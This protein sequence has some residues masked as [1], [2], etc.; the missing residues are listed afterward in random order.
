MHGEN[1]TSNQGPVE[2]G[3]HTMRSGLSAHPALLIPEWRLILH[4][5]P[6][7]HISVSTTT[8][9]LTVSSFFVPHFTQQVF[10]SYSVR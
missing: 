4:H 1:M 10:H 3:Y 9:S 5:P 8:H 6:R 2:S 7:P